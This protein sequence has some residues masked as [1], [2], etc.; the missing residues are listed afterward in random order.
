MKGASRTMYIIGRIFCIIGIVFAIAFIVTGIAFKA[1]V[2]NLATYFEEQGLTRYDSEKEVSVL[3]TTLLVIGIV[4]LVWELVE[5]LLA[6]KASKAVT[7]GI[8]EQ[9]PH[10]LLI[11]IGVFGNIFFLLGGIFSLIQNQNE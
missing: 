6:T 5:F 11:I 3:A 8:K 10:I 7:N 4:M 2:G 1:N 9:W